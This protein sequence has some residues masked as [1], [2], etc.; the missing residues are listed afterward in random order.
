[1]EFYPL[2][3]KNGLIT[4]ILFMDKFKYC[5]LNNAITRLEEKEDIWYCDGINNYVLRIFRN[6]I[7]FAGRDDRIR[8]P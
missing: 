1:M 3:I 5:R 6:F 4:G 7:I 8:I 2:V